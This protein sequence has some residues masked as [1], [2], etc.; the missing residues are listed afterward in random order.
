M[1]YDLYILILVISSIDSNSI[2]YPFL[3]FD[4][5]PVGNQLVALFLQDNSINGILPPLQEMGMLLSV[6]NIEGNK[7]EGIIP[8]VVRF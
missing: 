8:E 4:T 2:L 6:F 7:V 1:Y 3:H 5:V